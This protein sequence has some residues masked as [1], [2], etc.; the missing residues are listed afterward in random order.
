VALL[1]T[2]VL[3]S[4]LSS[5]AASSLETSLSPVANQVRRFADIALNSVAALR[6]AGWAWR[7]W[8]PMSIHLILGIPCASRA[9][10]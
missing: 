9:A 10:S 8:G 1:A 3:N 4:G 5:R 2:I 7:S 6:G